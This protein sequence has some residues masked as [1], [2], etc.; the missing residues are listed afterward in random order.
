[1]FDKTLKVR[2]VQ[3]NPVPREVDANIRYVRDQMNEAESDVVVFPELFISGYQ[4]ERLEDVALSSGG[5]WCSDLA[6]VCAATTSG[7]V[8]GFVEQAEGGFF[9]SM[10]VI[11]VDGTVRCP[12]R[13]T[14]LFGSERDVFIAGDDIAP[15]ELCGASVG[16]LNC[17]ELEFPEVARTL[18]LK[19]ADL[20]LA[21]SA[22]MHPFADEHVVATRGRVFENRIP[23]C[24]ANRVGDESGYEFCG[25]SCI[26]AANGNVLD[27]L[28]SSEVNSL[29]A[30]VVLGSSAEP[31]MEMVSQ[32]R[33]EL[34]C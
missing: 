24:Y 26:I 4:T 16:V 2:A 30:S 5:T 12:I 9:N 33:P 21:G 15:V 1:M 34:Y 3:A 19:G 23:L 31:N 18:R 8:V 17:F 29:V 13:K 32:R 28:D 25:G 7:L 20:F 14:H 11:D 22:N 6:E 27:Q 10:L